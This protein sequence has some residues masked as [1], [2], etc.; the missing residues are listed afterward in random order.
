MVGDHAATARISYQEKSRARMRYRQSSNLL[1]HRYA[2]R[3]HCLSPL[4]LSVI[5]HLLYNH[6]FHHVHHAPGYSQLA[7]GPL[8]EA[9]PQLPLRPERQDAL[10]M[11]LEPVV[12]QQWHSP[13]EALQPDPVAAA[14][15]LSQQ[16]CLFSSSSLR[17]PT[18]SRPQM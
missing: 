12:Q 4:H 3:H 18:L 14:L 10:D 6:R 16:L 2:H 9:P 7:Q 5:T 13:V 17:L 15:S 11:E 1:P 8:E